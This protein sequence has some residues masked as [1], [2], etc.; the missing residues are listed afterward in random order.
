MLLGTVLSCLVVCHIVG[1]EV[2]TTQ[3]IESCIEALLRVVIAK[4]LSYYT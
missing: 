1:P 2:M 3:K 4:N